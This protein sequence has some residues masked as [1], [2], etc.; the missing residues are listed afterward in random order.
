MRSPNTAPYGVGALHQS[1][2]ASG[3]LTVVEM[4]RRTQTSSLLK[5]NNR[6]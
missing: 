1:A 2:T 3:A 4:S 5:K 6:N